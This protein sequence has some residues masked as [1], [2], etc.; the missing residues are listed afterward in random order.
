M[1]AVPRVAVMVT[2]V[3]AVGF[4]GTIENV[5]LVAPAAIVIDAV[6]GATVVL[7]LFRVIFT[8]DEP[9]GPESV[10]VPVTELLLLP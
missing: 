8:P 4:V 6:T 7:E 5:P 10:T 1:E 3:L 2:L 9:A